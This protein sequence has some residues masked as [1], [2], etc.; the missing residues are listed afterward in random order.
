M[1]KCGNIHYIY[2]PYDLPYALILEKAESGEVAA[3]S[4]CNHYL[5]FTTKLNPGVALS[6]VII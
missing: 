2:F 3:L 5:P 4:C 1:E 6:V